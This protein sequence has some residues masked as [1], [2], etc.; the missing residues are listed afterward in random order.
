MAVHAYYDIY[1]DRCTAIRSGDESGAISEKQARKLATENGWKRKRNPITQR[2][3]D[4]CPRCLKKLG[5]NTSSG[6]KEL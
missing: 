1:C 4:V 5:A 6:V 2:L 3:E